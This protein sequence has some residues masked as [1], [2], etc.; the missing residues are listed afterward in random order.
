MSA[1]SALN[2]AA[3]GPTVLRWG[4]LERLQ[5]PLVGL[6]LLVFLLIGWQSRE[7]PMQAAGDDEFVYLALSKSL[8]NGSYRE[9]YRVDQ[10]WHVQYPP[11]YPAWLIPVRAVIGEQLTVI[12]AVNLGLAALGVLLL[13]GG[14]RRLVG[15]PLALVWLLLL[16]LNRSMLTVA[17]LSSE[18]LFLLLSGGTLYWMLAPPDSPPRKA[19]PAIV[20]ALLAF[21][22]RS[23][24]LAL[25]AGVGV[26]LWSR[27]DWK[28][29]V[30]WAV[31]SALVVGGWF[32]YSMSGWQDPSLASY[33]SD[34]TAGIPD[35]GGGAVQHLVER[36]WQGGRNYATT[37]MPHSIGLPTIPGTLVDNW[38]WLVL[39]AVVMTIGFVLL[40]KRW[41][42]AAAYVLCYILFVLLWPWESARLLL[43]L[44]PFGLLAILLGAR[45]AT[46]FLKPG[47]RGIVLGAVL[48]LLGIGALQSGWERLALYRNCDRENPY[49]SPGCYDSRRLVLLAGSEYVRT[50]GK[51]S[52]LIFTDQPASVAFF[53]G[54]LTL[55]A[56]MAWH[57]GRPAA[58]VMKER[59]VRYVISN[60]SWQAQ[61]MLPGCEALRVEASYPPEGLLLA[62]SDSTAGPQ[63]DACGA[64]Q[65]VADLNLPP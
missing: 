9:T 51:P 30:G 29:L 48:V 50:H 40:W 41:R 33:A 18:G 15:V 62:L 12:S 58:Q 4:W 43:P 13:F 61:R 36:V 59:G 34:F 21:L 63:P 3:A 16:V 17:D 20:L 53:S 25:V 64:L 57:S 42:G 44:V 31:A 23:I 10:P 27:R 22:T 26:W 8:E 56:W 7:P 38:I 11:V 37:H 49:Q 24:G 54:R 28:G 52:D 35:S 55:P 19:W 6:L 39:T 46:G 5:Y 47:A 32:A 2:G 65:R 45:W 1:S 60:R 14:V